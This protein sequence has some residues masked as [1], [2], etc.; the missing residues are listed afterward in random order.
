MS[1]FWQVGGPGGALGKCLG[2]LEMP[3]N[4]LD[5]QIGAICEFNGCVF[6]GANVREVCGSWTHSWECHVGHGTCQNGTGAFYNCA[7]LWVGGMF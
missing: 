4:K 6:S 7:L 2:I 3:T 1:A 5:M